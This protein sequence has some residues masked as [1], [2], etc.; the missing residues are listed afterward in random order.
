MPSTQ[1]DP[2]ILY[3][4]VGE[5]ALIESKA[6]RKRLLLNLS[7]TCRTLLHAARVIIF[8]KIKWPHQNQHDEESGLLFPPEVLWPYIK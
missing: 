2:D 1:L 8:A 6:Q 3:E 7:L 4:I 5:V